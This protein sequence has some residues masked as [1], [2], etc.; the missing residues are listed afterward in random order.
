MRRRPQARGN[1]GS[2]AHRGHGRRRLIGRRQIGHIIQHR[3]G[4]GCSQE[5]HHHRQQQSH[6]RQD[7]LLG[8]GAAPDGHRLPAAQPG[9]QGQKQHPDRARFQSAGAGAGG[10]AGK[11]QDN[12]HHNGD[13]GERA[14]ADGV[15]AGG[16]QGSGLE[17][18]VEQALPKGHGRHGARV[19]VF[20]EQEEGRAEGQQE[21]SHNNDHLAV[22][23]QTL[24]PALA[25]DVLPD[26]EAQTAA[27]DEDGHREQHYRVVVISRQ[28]ADLLRAEDVKARIAEGGNGGEYPF[29]DGRHS[30]SRPETDRQDQRTDPLKGEGGL[31]RAPDQPGN[32]PHVVQVEVGY[33][34]EPLAQRQLALDQQR[35]E[36]D[37]GHKAQAAQLDEQDDDHLAKQGP[38]RQGIHND[39]SRHTS[40]GRGSEQCREKPTTR[41][42]HRGYRQ[43]QQQSTGQND[44]GKGDGNHLGGTQYPPSFYL[45]A[46]ICHLNKR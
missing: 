27:G 5:E 4:N 8:N 24:P 46:Q 40:G 15:E 10:A 29:P 45:G 22:Q 43:H 3:N 28:A 20:A 32:I 30:M 42:R 13:V 19:I 6:G 9:A 35:H 36:E 25:L 21:Q 23:G 16:A 14:L 18:G 41:P 33:R 44:G 31:Q 34:H 7:L 2:H 39:Q 12:T 17:E 26:K 38:G 11:H 37:D 1:T